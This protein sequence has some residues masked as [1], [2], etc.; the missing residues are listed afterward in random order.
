VTTAPAVG[1]FRLREFW[2]RQIRVRSQCPPGCPPV[3]RVMRAQVLCEKRYRVGAAPHP[4]KV[5][6]WEA[7]TVGETRTPS[8]YHVWP[9]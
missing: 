9:T 8:V 7:A 5:T 6:G 1:Y 4:G 2:P 3:V